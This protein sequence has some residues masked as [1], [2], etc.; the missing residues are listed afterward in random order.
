MDE[1]TEDGFWFGILLCFFI[2]STI[3]TFIVIAI[4]IGTDN[5]PQWIM[6]MCLLDDGLAFAIGI[7]VNY[8][9]NSK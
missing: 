5:E 6:I 9:L 7:C 3:L 2:V 1:K 4:T 8:F